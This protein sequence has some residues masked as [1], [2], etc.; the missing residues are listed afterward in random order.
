MNMTL[1]RFLLFSL[2]PLSLFSCLQ[3]KPEKEI[4]IQSKETE[5]L[6]SWSQDVSQSRLSENKQFVI[7]IVPDMKEMLLYD[8][9]TG[10]EQSINL[11]I[12]S[13]DQ[14]II[15]NSEEL[16]YVNNDYSSKIRKSQLVKKN[17]QSGEES[18]LIEN[19]RF[20][21]LLSYSKPLSSILFLNNDTLYSYNLQNN[22]IDNDPMIENISFVTT[23]F[24]IILYNNGEYNVINPLGKEKYLWVSTSPDHSKIVFTVAGQ[25]TYIYNIFE[26]STLNI[27]KLHAPKW[28]EDGK[29]VI[30][31]QEKDNGHDFIESDIIMV[32]AENGKQIN[33]TKNS[34][35]IAL[36]PEIDLDNHMV[37][38]NDKRGDV[39]SMKI[40]VNDQ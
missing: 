15:P 39:Y 24:D 21:K 4:T 6:K 19:S 33:L 31:M 1:R 26:N 17:L 10:Q 13:V 7:G 32:K 25:D 35:V 29:W 14:L 3:P 11:P 40:A 30:G 37:Y 22:L 2:L 34:D 20:I 28:S 38:F 36:F 8:R 12:T 5:I 9:N 23:S 27:G 16:I 18:L